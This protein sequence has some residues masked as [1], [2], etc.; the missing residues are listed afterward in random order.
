MLP[1]FPKSEQLIRETFYK[2][3]FLARA[4]Q[5]PPEAMPPTQRLAE[6]KV[7]DYQRVDGAIKPLEIETFRVEG[8]Y[9][10]S[11][12]RGL[13]TMEALYARAEEI[14]EK[15]GQEEFKGMLNAIQKVT[16]ETGN[17][18][19][20]ENRK[21]TQEAVLRMLSLPEEDFDER[22]QSRSQFILGSELDFIHFQRR[23]LLGNSLRKGIF[24]CWCAKGDVQKL[25][26]PLAEALA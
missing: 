3:M 20:V 11:D 26:P 12:G 10:L 14:G 15:M 18:V 13:S 23:S 16:E 21:L 5:L 8:T 1:S 2:R 17:V 9:D 25:P 6:G 24:A 4:R 7:N 19:V 22:G